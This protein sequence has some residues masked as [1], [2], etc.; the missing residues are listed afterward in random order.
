[1]N[2]NRTPRTRSTVV[3]RPATRRAAVQHFW[4]RRLSVTSSPLSGRA[5]EVEAQYLEV[6]EEV[7][8]AIMDGES[9]WVVDSLVLER[10][11]LARE[12]D[13]LLAGSR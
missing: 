11:E 12:L 7:T 4:D 6:C 13:G 9:G 3:R 10:D 5:V 1:M 2:R 8:E